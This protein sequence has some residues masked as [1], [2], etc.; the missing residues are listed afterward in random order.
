MTDKKMTRI[1]AERIM[2]WPYIDQHTPLRTV[3]TDGFICDGEPAWKSSGAVFG[4]ALFNP[5]IR[6]RDCMAA[7]DKFSKGRITKLYRPYENGGT[8]GAAVHGELNFE[9]PSRRRA[10]CECMI[11]AVPKPGAKKAQERAE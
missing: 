3:E 10:M 5:L 1:I 9:S 11:E 8:W 6:D 7:W 4:T 2:G